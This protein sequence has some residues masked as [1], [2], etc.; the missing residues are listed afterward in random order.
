MSD[1]RE[2]WGRARIEPLAPLAFAVSTGIVVDRYFEPLGTFAWSVSAAAL[3]SIAAVAWRPRWVGGWAIV[4]AFVALGGAWHHYWWSDLAPGDL[5]RATWTPGERRPCWVRGVPVEASTFRAGDDGPRD[6]GSTRTVLALT[7]INDGRGWRPASGKLQT[8]I[9]GD[10]SDLEAGSPIEAAGLIAPIEGPVNPGE[11]DFRP[12]LR[13][14]GI[15]LRLSVDEPSGVWPDPE[16]ADWP[17]TRYLGVIRERAA[18][19]LASGLDPAVVPLAQALLLGRREAVDPEVNDAFART[20]T[21]HLLAIS[22]LHLQVLAVALGAC[23]RA[24]GIGRKGA[25]GVVIAGTVTYAVLVGLAPSVVRSA[26][27]TLGGCFAGMKDRCVGRANL[28]SGAALATLLHNP[29]DLFDVG[30]QLSFL[31]VA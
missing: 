31:A 5:A 1:N 16:G 20:G 17:L 11:V 7:G 19:L 28:L 27:M 29:A 13:S 4:A 8:W 12:I 10:R 24:M 26:V 23:V 6:R 2:S 15:R 14:R 30:C 25:N 9:A 21:T 18:R 22:G 3:A